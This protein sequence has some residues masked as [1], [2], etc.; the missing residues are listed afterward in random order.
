MNK[1]TKIAII[2]VA[3]ITFTTWFS[4]SFAFLLAGS[5][6]NT[7]IGL[8][9]EKDDISPEKI[10]KFRNIQKLLEKNYYKEINDDDLIEGA[11]AGMVNALD[12]P[13]TVYFNA[14]DMESF[15]EKARGSYGGIGVSIN[16]D[17]EGLLT[18]VKPLEESPAYDAGIKSGDKIIMVNDTDVTSIKDVSL[19]INMIKGEQ[20]TEV[21]ITVYRTS[22]NETLSFDIT[23]KIIKIKNIKSEVI[24]ND[25]GYI[26]IV[27]F[28][29]DIANEFNK[30][31]DELLSVGIKGIIIDLRD[32]T[33]GAYPEV[34][35]ITDRLVPEGII[36]YTEDKYG[37]K[38]YEYSDAEE[39]EVPLTIL[40]NEYSAS[41]SEVLAG[42]VKDYKKGTLI[43][44]K[45]YGKGLVQVLETLEDGSGIKIT[46]ST[47]FTPSGKN[48]HGIGISPDI[49]VDLPEEY[50]NMPLSDIPREEDTQ[51]KK[52]VE[53]IENM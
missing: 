20:D 41:A 23:R 26:K 49:E 12:D 15:N 35:S 48:I 1:N 5:L 37:N 17:E 3:V 29:E 52:A 31:L 30:K 38:N 11:I 16:I 45:S 50:K 6:E 19:I 21:K 43:G 34:V 9:F 42:A 27:T 25:I 32:N 14:K 51:I 10:R 8:L 46:V 28:D 40:I 47:Y 33:G 24:E 53:I 36:V 44:T 13:Y 7:S 39:L 2:L 22:T 4:I 18:V